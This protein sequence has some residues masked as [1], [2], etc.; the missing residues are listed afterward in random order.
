MQTEK[1]PPLLQLAM[2]PSEPDLALMHM[3]KDVLSDSGCAVVIHWFGGA[4]W[5]SDLDEV[6]IA[7][8]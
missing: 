2:A 7:S 1:A 6:A 3:P 5:V 8:A 4:E